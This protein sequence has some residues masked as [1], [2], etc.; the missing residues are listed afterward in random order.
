MHLQQTPETVVRHVGP[1]YWEATTITPKQESR[2]V[3]L[4]KIYTE[5]IL[6]TIL[7]PIIDK[8]YAV[9]LRVLDWLVTNYSK[10]Q[11]IVFETPYI[12][13]ITLQ[14]QKPVAVNIH[15]DYKTWLRTHKRRNF[16]MFRRSQRISFLLDN[17]VHTTT[18]AQLNFFYWAMSYGI[19]DY[20]IKHVKDIESD[21]SSTM[22]QIRQNKLNQTTNE[23]NPR[24]RELSKAPDMKC[25]VYD[26]SIPLEV[27]K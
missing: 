1:F 17:R 25:R 12:N 4:S 2:L 6:R 3:F 27:L 13:T 19:I 7:V 20:A 18:V 11:H 15:R 16:D 21:H 5:H 23:K 22:R 24:R 14:K 9:S 8:D 26:I 10:K